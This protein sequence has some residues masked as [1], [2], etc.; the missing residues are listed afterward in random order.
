[1]LAYQT[2]APTTGTGAGSKPGFWYNGGTAAAP[3]WVRLTDGS[4]VSYDPAT[5]LQVGPVKGA[6]VNV[7]SGTAVSN[8]AYTLVFFGPSASQPAE[9]AGMVYLAADLLAAG[10]RAGPISS[11]GFEVVSKGTGAGVFRNFTIRLANTTQATATATFLPGATTV[12]TNDV[13]TTVGLNTFP[14]PVPFAWDGTSNLYVETCFANTTP[15]GF[16]L[17]ALYPTAYPALTYLDA[18]NACAGT[19][20]TADPYLAV[21]YL[22]QPGSYTLPAAGARPGRCSPSRPA[23][24]WRFKPHNGPR[25]APACTLPKWP[26]TWASAQAAPP[27]SWTWRAMPW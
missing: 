26:A 5:G 2:D 20:G 15:I 14:F 11:L 22:T 27:R 13:V 6:L 1:M 4:G 7:P 8:P 17:V 3:A 25:P 24:R 21:L 18:V 19:T 23:G 12:F 10:Y 9:H 16:D